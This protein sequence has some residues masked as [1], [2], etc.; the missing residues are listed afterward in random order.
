MNRIFPE[1]ITNLPKADIPLDGVTAYL[2]QSDTNQ[3]IFMQFE[4]DVDLPVHAHASQMGIVLEGRIELIIDGKKQCFTKGDRY[5][6][7]A[8]V[9]HSGKIYTGYADIT[10]FN[11]PDRYAKK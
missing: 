6:I 2:S 11:E 10:F 1:P 3:I 5:Y 7:P 4:K 9:K 8:G